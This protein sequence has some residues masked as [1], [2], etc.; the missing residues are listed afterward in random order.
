MCLRRVAKRACGKSSLQQVVRILSRVFCSKLTGRE[1]NPKSLGYFLFVVC[2]GVL[3]V[4]PTELV[5]SLQDTPL[6]E[7]VI[8]IG[9]AITAPRIQSQLTPRA[10]TKS[11][12]TICVVSLVPAVAL[13]QISHYALGEAVRASLSFSKV[14]L[15]YLFLVAVLNS[16]TRLRG[17][18]VWLCVFI[19]ALASLAILQ[20]YQVIENAALSAHRENVFDKETG[21]VLGVNERLSGAGI[22]A[23]PN[24]LSRILVVGIAL[25]LFL[26][27]GGAPPLLRPLCVFAIVV[28]GHAL[29]LT[30]SRGGFLALLTTLFVLCWFRLGATRTLS[31]TVAAIPVLAFAIQ[32]RQTEISTTEGT[33]LERIRLW[34]DGLDALRSS[35]L[36]GIGMG[37]YSEVTGGQVAHNS[38]VHAYVELGFVGGTLFLGAMLGAFWAGSLLRRRSISSGSPRLLRMG[39]YLLAI[40]AGYAVGMLSSSRCYAFPTYYLLGFVVAYLRL[41]RSNTCIPEFRL[42][43]RLIVLGVLLSCFVLF[44]I[45]VFVMTSGKFDR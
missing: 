17:F 6:Y 34:S 11:P 1:V 23:N 26:C 44:A 15:S 16:T 21:D 33:G 31:L 30:Q 8:L 4:R 45:Q 18:M 36:F 28:F 19:L 37:N 38:F 3:F 24:D 35:P 13:S 27:D 7:V 14:V 22:F 32:G 40:L 41:A 25:A 20:H 43:P 10:L 29:L 5:G 42:S 2:T 12:I 9:L 39:D